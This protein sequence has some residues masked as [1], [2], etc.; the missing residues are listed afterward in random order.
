M[1][2]NGNWQKKTFLSHYFQDEGLCINDLPQRANRSYDEL[3]NLVF[4]YARDNLAVIKVFL[5]DPYYTSIKRDVAMTQVE[6]I[7]NAGGLLGLCMGMSFVSM[8]EIVYHCCHF[9][10][11]RAKRAVRPE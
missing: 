11:H 1:R 5:K 7:A 9:I 8:F 6:F 4:D 3:D 2:N 10:I